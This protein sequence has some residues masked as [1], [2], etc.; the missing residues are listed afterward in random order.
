VSGGAPRVVIDTNVLLDI[1]V[2]DDPSA[3][4]LRAGIEAG[5]VRA[6]RSEQCD[7]EFA[8]V[9]ARG[10]FGLDEAARAVLLERWA[11]CSE[12][13]APPPAAP[14]SCADPD[15]QKF[16]DAAF[17]AGADLLVTRDKALLQL[18][19]RAGALGLRIT[20]AAEAMTYDRLH[21]HAGSTPA[22]RPSTNATQ[23]TSTAS[24]PR[25]EPPSSP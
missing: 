8:E 18:A 12:P 20:A 2:F 13:V 6:L 22:V 10:Q 7:A 25:S 24:C 4:P 11:A 14:L 19:R 1:W 5:R 21:S 9:L 16:L 15:D 17:A 3:R 23:C